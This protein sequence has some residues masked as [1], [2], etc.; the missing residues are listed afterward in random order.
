MV[1]FM[2]GCLT[3]SDG[4][5]S[6]VLIDFINNLKRIKFYNKGQ[7]FVNRVD[8]EIGQLFYNRIKLTF[9]KTKNNIHTYQFLLWSDGDEPTCSSKPVNFKFPE[10]YTLEAQKGT[11]TKKLSEIATHTYLIFFLHKN[12]L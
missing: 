2:L 5:T 11:E 1:F 12:P 10:N 7:Y 4:L 6:Q 3:Y 8:E 9:L